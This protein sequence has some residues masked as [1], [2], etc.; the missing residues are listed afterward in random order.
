M[1]AEFATLGI[2]GVIIKVPEAHSNHTL[3]NIVT[4]QKK[5]IVGIIT[6]E[7]VSRSDEK[8]KLIVDKPKMS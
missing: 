1:E 4:S 5:P 6:S 7:M 8:F 3:H 2:E